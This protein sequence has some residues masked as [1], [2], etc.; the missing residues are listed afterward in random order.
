MRW[1]CSISYTN[2]VHS[3]FLRLKVVPKSLVL[4]KTPHLSILK[5][6]FDYKIKNFKLI[7]EGQRFAWIFDNIVVTT[8]YQVT[9]IFSY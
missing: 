5:L 3:A 6:F 1:T 7:Y 4:K 8:F 9:I 2:K